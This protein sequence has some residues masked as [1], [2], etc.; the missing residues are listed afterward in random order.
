[1]R[2]QAALTKQQQREA[3]REYIRQQEE[4]VERLNFDVEQ[5]MSELDSLLSKGLSA[6]G[7][8]DFQILKQRPEIPPFQPGK[9]AEIEPAPSLKDYVPPAPGVFSLFW[10]PAKRTHAEATAAA[11]QRYNDEMEKHAEREDFRKRALSDARFFHEKEVEKLEAEAAAWN[12]QI[13]Q[14]A[15]EY[16]EGKAK[17]VVEY[18]QLVLEKSDYPEGFPNASRIAYVP[19]STQLILEYELPS[20]DVVPEVATHKYV[21]SKDEIV[22]TARAAAHRRAAYVSIIAQTTLRT[23]HEVFCATQSLVVESIVFNGHVSAI[24]KGTGRKVHPCIVTVRVTRDVFKG[25]NLANVEPQACLKTLSASV[26]PNPA[27]L[28]PVR[29]VLE[30]NMVDPRFVQEA[31]ILTTLDQR[32]NLMELSPNEFESLITNLFEK[33]GLETRQTQASRDG[34]VDCVAYDMECAPRTGGFA[35]QVEYRPICGFHV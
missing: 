1:M 30:F 35:S 27:E 25:L 29:P 12:L 22:T 19:D 11:S 18:C 16:G 3:E 15:Q 2:Q 34:G 31:D 17:A 4:E 7:P 20:L 9:L 33:M 6:A 32:P 21:K 23:L 14:F 28:A 13:D 8:L 24:D 10:P 26:S 5:Q